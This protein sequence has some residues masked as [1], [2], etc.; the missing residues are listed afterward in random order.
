M[1]PFRAMSS[2]F[3]L[4]VQRRPTNKVPRILGRA[5][6]DLRFRGPLSRNPQYGALKSSLP[7]PREG[8]SI[9]NA[10][11]VVM[12][13]PEPYKFI[14]FG[15]IHGPKPYKFIGFGDIHGPKPY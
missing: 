13:G 12:S 8:S 10:H 11:L 2:H 9:L 1:I 7:G 4:F 5:P 14:G 6:P 15:D 3:L